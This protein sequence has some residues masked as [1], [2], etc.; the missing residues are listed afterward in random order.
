MIH[1]FV[2]GVKNF[3]NLVHLYRVRKYYSWII[4]HCDL[5]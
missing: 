5:L 3:L 4:H 1:S 2:D